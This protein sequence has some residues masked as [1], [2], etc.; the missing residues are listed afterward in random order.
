MVLIVLPDYLLDIDS[1][2]LAHYVAF[3]VSMD[4]KNVDLVY[5]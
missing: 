4:V 1:V 5:S 2:N 3:V